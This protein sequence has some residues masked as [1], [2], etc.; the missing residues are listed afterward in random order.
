MPEDLLSFGN[1]QRKRKV[2]LL[3][4]GCKI[5]QYDSNSMA[6][7]IETRGH[8]IVSD[9]SE[10]DVIV[11]NTCTVTGKTDYK[12]RQL[13]RRAV[14]EN[15]SAVIVVTGCY[16]QVR[17]EA[18]A[19]IPGVDHVLGNSEKTR[20]ASC[21]AAFGKRAVAD[22]CVGEIPGELGSEEELLEVH[23][24]TTRAF[25]KIQDGCNDSC[26]Y[27]IVP[28]ARGRSRSLRPARVLEKLSLFS[29]RGFQEVV[30]CGVHLGVYGQDL[31][32]LTSLLALLDRV[33]QEAIVPRVR[34]SSIEPNEI[35]E[36]FVG[37]F[38]GAHCLCPHFHLP[39]QS[40]DEGVLRAM[41]RKY[42]PGS[43]ASLVES[44][45]KRI[46]EAAIG[47]DVIAGF[48]GE[49]ERAFRN[50][51][52]LLEALP[53]SYFHVF[54]FSPRPGTLASRMP[55]PIPP[56]AVQER[57]EELRRLGQD[58]RVGFYRQFLH[59]EVEVLVETKRDRESRL[60]RGFSRNY[61]PVL[62]PG[63]DAWQRKRIAVKVDRVHGRRVY[64]KAVDGAVS[65]IGAPCAP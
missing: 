14:E 4:L 62:F 38:P 36:E 20:L 9:A 11:I 58:K 19:A 31:N 33:E 50:T 16:A 1:E 63:E 34:I 3:T 22:I 57:A 5:N 45:R 41:R 65:R 23:S 43:F 61:V 21:I 27:C 15:P 48:P 49:S 32:P 6:S 46:P 29:S 13:I 28:R 53:V 52:E 54:P 35:E 10:A 42:T 39:V 7:G 44:I 51:L 2:A 8:V 40:G 47:V 60:L 55:D 17:P 64:G 18:I 59:R 24:G 12:C 26:A 56:E 37:L 25:L 30:L